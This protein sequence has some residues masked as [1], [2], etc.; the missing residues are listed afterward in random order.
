MADLAC[1]CCILNRDRGG[2]AL[3]ATPG[4]ALLDWTELRARWL[5]Q[6]LAAMRAAFPRIQFIVALTNGM[7]AFCRDAGVGA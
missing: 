4:I 6:V 3:E 7:A 2:G 5:P 1:R